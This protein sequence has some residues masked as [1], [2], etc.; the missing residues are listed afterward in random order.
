M[1]RGYLSYPRFCFFFFFCCRWFQ[2][3]AVVAPCA[4]W[5]PLDSHI[6]AWN[7]VFRWWEYLLIL[8]WSKELQFDFDVPLCTFLRLSFVWA[9]LNSWM[10]EFNVFISYEMSLKNSVMIFFALSDVNSHSRSLLMVL[11]RYTFH[12]PF[13]FNPHVFYI[14]SGFVEGSVWLDF[15]FL[16]NLTMIAFMCC[17]H[18]ITFNIVMTG[19]L[20]A[21][22]LLLSLCLI[23]S[24]LFL[25]LV[26]CLL[27][28]RLCDCVP[29][30]WFWAI[31]F[32]MSLYSF[33]HVSFPWACWTSWMHGYRVFIKFWKKIWLL[34]AWLFSLSSSS[35]VLIGTPITPLLGLLKLSYGSGVLCPPC[36]L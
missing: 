15:A 4:L 6:P 9:L 16:S 29:F 20:S 8:T 7:R 3:E 24:L 18:A 13:A 10:C 32:Y 36:T 17:V 35:P 25:L 22:L 31:R 14:S 30:H 33:L 5:K 23:C 11:A 1:V 12:C 34:N 21:L 2:H 19:L 27:L 26:S 28:D